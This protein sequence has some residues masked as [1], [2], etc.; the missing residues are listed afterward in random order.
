MF[1][2]RPHTIG[3]RFATRVATKIIPDFTV[4]TLSYGYDPRRREESGTTGVIRGRSELCCRCRSVL[5]YRSRSVHSVD[6][7]F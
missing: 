2:T 3:D 5:E 7:P 4:T 1:N 6:P